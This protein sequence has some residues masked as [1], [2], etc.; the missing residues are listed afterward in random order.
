MP[1]IEELYQRMADMTHERCDKGCRAEAKWSCCSREYCEEAIRWAWKRWGVFL[2]ETGHERLPL[3]GPDGC[4]AAP[5]F[6]PLC[7]LHICDRLVMVPG[8]YEEYM[9]LRRE[10]NRAETPHWESE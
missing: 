1:G 3:L 6:R 5:H 4:T 8:F 2:P 9:D 7:T 10:I